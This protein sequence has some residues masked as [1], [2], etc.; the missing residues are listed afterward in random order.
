MRIEEL[1]IGLGVQRALLRCEMAVRHHAIPTH[2]IVGH[3]P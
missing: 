1:L 2:T 3:P